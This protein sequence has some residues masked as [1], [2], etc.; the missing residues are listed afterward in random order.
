M[1]TDLNQIQPGWDVIDRLGDKIGD[2]NEVQSDY[3][4]LTKGLI[5]QKDLYVPLDAVKKVD[6]AEQTVMLNVRKA[7]IDETQWAQAPVGSYRG[8][9]AEGTS[10]N[11]TVLTMKEERIRADKTRKQTGEMAVG[12]RVVEQAG[13]DGRPG[14]ARRGRGDPP[15]RRSGGHRQRDLHRGRS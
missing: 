3:L 9:F 15:T 14:D 8:D 4:V 11:D 6:P 12:K 10:D 1:Q 5:F 7:D 13:R 2:A